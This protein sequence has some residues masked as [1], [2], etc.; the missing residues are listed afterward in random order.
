MKKAKLKVSIPQNRAEVEALVSQMSNLTNSIATVTAAMNKH[1]SEIHALY[2]PQIAGLVERLSAQRDACEQWAEANPAEFAKKKSIEFPRGV[3][4]FRIGNH[5]VKTLSKWTFEKSLEVMR[6]SVKWVTCIRMREVNE[7]DKE[8][9][10]TRFTSGNISAEALSEVGLKV[11]QKE[12]FYA[13][14][15]LEKPGEIRQAA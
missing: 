11:V 8:H 2:D 13:D 12:S 14:A 6:R 5:E 4:G 15:K 1:V 7:I 10:I 3:I 9:I